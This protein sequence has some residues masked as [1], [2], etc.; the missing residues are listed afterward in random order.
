MKSIK[1]QANNKYLKGFIPVFFASLISIS[2]TGCTCGTF[3]W[4]TYATHADVYTHG[5]SLG[6]SNL[7]LGYVSNT[8]FEPYLLGK[9]PEIIE[10]E[11]PDNSET[12]I[13]WFAKDVKAE[14]LQELLYLD[15]YSFDSLLPVTTGHYPYNETEDYG[16][17]LYDVPL[18]GKAYVESQAA[19]KSKYV[20]LPLAFRSLSEIDNNKYIP[21]NNIYL[22]KASVD[23]TYDD[24]R[25]NE[26][27]EAVRI[28][29]LDKLRNESHLINP[30]AKINGE[31][32]VGGV[33]NLNQ[34]DYY[35]YIGEVGEEREIFYGEFLNEEREY[36]KPSEED[37]PP[38]GST[39]LIPKE[40]AT[41]F[42]A[43]HKK[44]VRIADIEKASPLKATYES[45][46]NFKNLLTPIAITGNRDDG[47]NYAY[48]EIDIFV[49]GWDKAVID[50]K[51]G[52][53]FNLDFEFRTV[54]N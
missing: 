52:L 25:D 39:T 24:I 34:D 31:T 13:Y 3:A 9:Y 41:T 48:A 32:D 26:L 5:I 49:E 15:G 16:F 2:L 12:Y 11:H 37:T 6:N 22:T 20:K 21:N 50:N 54:M 1:D 40:E 38:E 17:S 14:I 51:M 28:Y 43:N 47:L 35:D 27:E 29:T 45:F 7:Q 23:P 10:E 36:L 30:R 18:T 44:D 33:L 46:F 4:F 8:R 19:S 53:K 42:N